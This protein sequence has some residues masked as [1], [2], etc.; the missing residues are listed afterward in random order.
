MSDLSSKTARANHSGLEKRSEIKTTFRASRHI[1]LNC[2]VKQTSL[3][4]EFPG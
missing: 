4:R 1:N 2:E 3:S